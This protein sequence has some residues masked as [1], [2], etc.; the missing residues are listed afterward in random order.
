MNRKHNFLTHTISQRMKTPQQLDLWHQIAAF[1]L[2]D[3]QSEFP[4]SK[5][6]AHEN[7]WSTDFT[8]RAI[9]E[10]KKFLFLCATLPDG[11]SPA[12]I[13][14]EVWHLHLTYTQSYWNDL[15]PN[16]LGFQLHHYPSKGGTA[17]NQKHQDWYRTTIEGYVAAFGQLPPTDIWDLPK[18]F[19]PNDYLPKDSP[20]IIHSSPKDIIGEE[21]NEPQPKMSYHVFKWAAFGLAAVMSVAALHPPLMK[22]SIFIQLYV[23]LSIIALGLKLWE[24]DF[25]KM[26]AHEQLLTFP[27]NL[28][29]YYGAWLMG[30]TDRVAFTALYEV[31]DTC[32]MNEE[33]KMMDFT[34][35]QDES[36]R[37]NP[38]YRTLQTVEKQEISVDFV[39]D[40]VQMF[41]R[42]I[43]NEL[44]HQDVLT[45]K[46]H[47]AGFTLV[48]TTFTLGFIRMIEGLVYEKPIG[49]LILTAV[50]LGIALI[51]TH[52]RNYLSVWKEAFLE[53]YHYT[54]TSPVWQCALN[55]A[56]VLAMSEW[57][58]INNAFSPP[59]LSSDGFG[60]GFDGGSSCSGGDG[61]GGCGGGCGGCGGC[62]GS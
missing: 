9:A 7:K 25:F 41:C 21:I 39:K 38:L 44:R 48:I 3:P 35:K 57:M 32:V 1:R 47:Y 26:Q 10:Y 36:L 49:F 33:R 8:L 11:A 34:L 24:N 37:H 52:Q 30:G 23:A 15:C 28:S 61:G 46:K 55:G 13:V 45:P 4:F 27:K 14:D 19:D 2:D 20:L 56:V 50:V 22:G 17:E 51:V 59:K 16:I 18:N 31:T 43:D 29:P 42:Y 6:L 60:Y 62:G 54:E 40:S 12:K 53:R 58:S 5:K